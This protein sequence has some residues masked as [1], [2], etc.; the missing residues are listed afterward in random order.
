MDIFQAAITG[1]IQ[2][3]TEFLPVSS[4]GHIVLVS[5]LYKILTG[6]DFTVVGKEEIFFD[7]MLHVGT[8]IAILVYFKQDL[9]EI[10]NNFLS[11]FK[12]KDFSKSEEARLPLFIA[13]GTTATILVVLPLRDFFEH[14]VRTPSA[15]GLVLIFT[16]VL[17]ISTEFLSS[18]FTQKVEKMDWKRALFIG[19]A[20]GFS[21]APG[22]SRSG[23]TIAAGLATG[24]SRV[25]AAKYSF[26]LSIPVIILAA[27][28]DLKSATLSQLAEYNWLA[29]FVGTF[30]AS[31]VGYFCIK[32]FI[33]FISKH[34]LN[35]FAYYCWGVGILMF[36]FLK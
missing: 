21:A 9:I 3:L 17:L 11:A 10:L 32:Y 25:T 23:S 8:L 28:Y 20:Q 36:F 1:F 30:I 34:K 27:L 13:L 31:V 29:I 12:N 16:G 15:V 22:L 5:T 14:L 6:G 24:L 18:K 7:I 35:V 33:I 19:I 2:G 4:S 26:L